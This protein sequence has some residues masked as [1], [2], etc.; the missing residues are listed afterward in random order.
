M[1]DTAPPSA[2]HAAIELSTR[3]KLVVMGAV[4]LGLFLSALDQT[5]VGTAL[6]RIVSDL[7]GN[8]LYVWVVT[9]Y[10]LTSTVTV[11]LYGKFGDVFGRKLMLTIGIVVFLVGSALCGLTVLWQTKDTSNQTGMALLI[12]FRGLQGIGAGCLFPISLAVIGDLFTPRERGR[13][14]GLFGAVFGISFIIG[15]FLGGFI[16]DTIGWE[17][18]FYVNLPIGIAALVAIEAVLPNV[19]S[20]TARLADLDYAG[21]VVFTAGIVPV[22]LGLTYKG[23]SDDATGR[24]YDWMT[25]NV[26]GLIAIGVVILAV[27][28]VIES[29]AKHPIIPLNL[30]TD[31]TIL[32]C[33]ATVFMVMC[34]M[35]SAMIFVP[36]YFQFVRGISATESGYA[37]W[38][39][40]VGLIGTS[41]AAG[42]FVSRTGRYKLLLVAAMAMLTFGMFLMT[43]I[44]AG[45]GF[46]LMWL[47]MAC[48]GLGIGP[49][50]SVITVV[51]QNAASREQLG[52]A[53]STMTFLRQIGGVVGLAVAATLFASSLTTKL[54]D[55]L[56]A[57]HVPQQIISQVGTHLASNQNDLTVGGDLHQTILDQVPPAARPR[58]APY[59]DGIV[60]GIDQSFSLSVGDVF[61]LAVITSAL[62]LLSTILIREIPL[63]AH[64][65]GAAVPPVPEAEGQEP[66]GDEEVPV[67]A[68]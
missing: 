45:T 20:V 34:G 29:R 8:N 35:F 33:N 14:Q 28:I 9:S 46:P 17:W 2:E 24:L 41:I 37:M 39:L 63:R 11:P 4:L 27:F 16:T 66:L 38:P 47:W 61:W 26:L 32:A 10:L 25:F 64:H 42:I 51:V 62:A 22:L 60:Q 40:L 1:A 36:R 12:V 54:P 50:M 13:Y 30:F 57:Q 7:H 49:S 18:V 31:R 43:H 55:Q 44:E 59:V 48:V 3:E 67:P 21:I 52:T 15:P 58:V 6:P 23:L 68:L 19:R 56:A 5:I 53:T 65:H